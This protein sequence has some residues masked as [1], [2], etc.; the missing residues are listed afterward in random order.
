MNDPTAFCRTVEVTHKVANVSFHR[1][2][3]LVPILP[4]G[5][6][7]VIVASKDIQEALTIIKH[8]SKSGTRAL[9]CLQMKL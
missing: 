2:G 3:H 5:S 9:I 1:I 4:L 8:G 7:Q 6:S